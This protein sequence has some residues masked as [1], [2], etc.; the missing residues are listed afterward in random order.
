MACST[1]RAELRSVWR[2][3]LE[4]VPVSIVCPVWR[5]KK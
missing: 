1:S 3:L 5:N 4:I 2:V